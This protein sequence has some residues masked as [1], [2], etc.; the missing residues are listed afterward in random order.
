MRRK[1]KFQVVAGREAAAVGGDLEVTL[2]TLATF[3][4]VRRGMEAVPATKHRL[5]NSY[6]LTSN[7][8]D[9]GNISAID[10]VFAPSDRARAI[11]NEE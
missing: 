2:A 3:H 6:S 1:F 5:V 10:H 11:G 8:S 4:V 7:V 9:G